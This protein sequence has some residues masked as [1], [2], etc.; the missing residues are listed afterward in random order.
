MLLVVGIGS[1]GLAMVAVHR[2][3]LPRAIVVYADAV[4]ALCWF[5]VAVLLLGRSRVPDAPVDGSGGRQA[6]STV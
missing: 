5:I 3:G 1:A 6:R 2:A 4:V